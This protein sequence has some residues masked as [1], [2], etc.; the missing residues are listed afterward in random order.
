LQEKE[1]GED[2]IVEV[3]MQ[4]SYVL[5]NETKVKVDLTKYVERHQ[6]NFDE[7]LDEYVTNDQ[8]TGLQL[9]FE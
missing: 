6:F 1:R 9:P 3:N 7:S 4:D 8:V 2:D 5:V